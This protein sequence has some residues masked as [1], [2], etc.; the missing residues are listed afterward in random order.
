MP[1][2]ER[3]TQSRS[4]MSIAILRSH[5]HIHAHFD[6]SIC[7]KKN[8]KIQSTPM[9]PFTMAIWESSMSKVYLS[10]SNHPIATARSIISYISLSSLSMTT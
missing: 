5:P 8:K 4:P 7:K 10:I 3:E 6:T 1:A 2:K 9:I